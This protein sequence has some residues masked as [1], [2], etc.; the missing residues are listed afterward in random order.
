MII[1]LDPVILC[2]VTSQSYLEI[3]FLSFVSQPQSADCLALRV[4]CFIEPNYLEQIPLIFQ[5]KCL[6]ALQ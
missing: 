2:I 5:Y 4:V 6:S 3:F 1:T